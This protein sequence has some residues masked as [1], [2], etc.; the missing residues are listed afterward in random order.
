MPRPE[1]LQ[2]GA[3]REQRKTV[4]LTLRG[5]TTTLQTTTFTASAASPSSNYWYYP[6]SHSR[7]FCLRRGNRIVIVMGSTPSG[8][9]YGQHEYN[10]GQL[11]RS[12]QLQAEL[13]A[14]QLHIHS[15]QLG[16]P[17]DRE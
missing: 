8:P 1:Y 13:L 14:V 2:I 5:R 9:N 11:V 16:N 15:F 17:P 10:G 3:V 7:R 4:E 6:F 12:L